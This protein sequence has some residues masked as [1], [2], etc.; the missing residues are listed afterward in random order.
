M[1][2]PCPFQGRHTS[3]DDS[4]LDRSA[5]LDPPQP[6]EEAHVL[7]PRQVIPQ[8]VVLGA[9]SHGGLDLADVVTDVELLATLALAA[10]DEHSADGRRVEPA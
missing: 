2:L 4:P 6:S 5:A 9:D 8:Q 7:R 10:T 3:S 1:C